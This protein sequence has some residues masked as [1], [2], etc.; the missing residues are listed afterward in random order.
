MHRQKNNGKNKP[1]LYDFHLKI[2]QKSC[3]ITTCDSRCL[4]SF[5]FHRSSYFPL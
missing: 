3:K 4:L 2:N 1:Y 5:I